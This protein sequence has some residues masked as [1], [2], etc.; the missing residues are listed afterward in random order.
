MHLAQRFV[1]YCRKPAD[2]QGC[3]EFREN[4]NRKIEKKK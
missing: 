1:V 4:K 3:R 2:A